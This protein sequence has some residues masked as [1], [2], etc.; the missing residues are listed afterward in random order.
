MTID[1]LPSKFPAGDVTDGQYLY[2]SLGSFWTQIFRDKD[3]LKGYTIGMAD[4]LIQAYFNLIE[5][6]KQYSVKDIDIFHKEKWLPLT[7]KKSEFNNTP[8]KFSSNS[9]VFGNQPNT[10]TFYAGQIFRFG[11]SKETGGRVFSFTP[12]IPLTRFGAIA[13]RIIAPSTVLLSG[14]DVVMRDGTLY[15]TTDLFN[16]PRIPTAKVID[17]FGIPV[18]FKDTTGKIADEEFIILWVYMAEIDQAALYD[19]FGV[20]L[21]LKLASSENY[22]EILKAIF[23][24]YVEGPTVKALTSAFAALAKAPIVIE[25]E[26]TIEDIYVD[27]HN[28][29]IITDKNVYKLAPDQKISPD[30]ARGTVFFAGEILSADV[31]VADSVIDPTWWQ[32]K[33]QTSKLAFASHVF[34]AGVKNQL[35][36]ENDLK[37]LT[38]TGAAATEKERRLIFPVLGR[39]ADVQAFQDY[40]NTDPNKSALLSLLNFKANTTSS[41]TINPVDFLF[42]NIFKNNTLFV[43][44]DFY[45]Q[46]QLDL[47]VSLLPLL[48][49]H[50]PPHIYLLLYITMLLSPDNFT[51]LNSG[52]RIAAFPGK[53]FSFDGSEYLTGAR[54]GLVSDPDYYKDYINRMFCI[55]IGPYRNSQPLHAAANLDELLLNSSSGVTAGSLRTDIPLSVHPPGEPNPRLPSTREIQSILLIDF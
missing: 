18:T 45:S 11:F 29:Y 43:K 14:I 39:P 8:F 53:F 21:D 30:V 32:K 33:V 7:I 12:N 40:I 5:V 2:R 24:L 1:F 51:G 26:E 36:F 34:I 52:L 28:Q 35:F 54:P 50:L 15:F 41:M 20:L 10:D 55:S 9:A 31:A 17:D 25:T 4:E 19:N 16:D 22:K 3:A 46:E 47:F 37:L 42:Q 23:N 6:I 48:Q 38:Y 13:N 49:E 27:E 44:L